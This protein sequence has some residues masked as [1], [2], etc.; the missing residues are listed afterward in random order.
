MDFEYLKDDEGNDI[1]LNKGDKI[2][3]SSTLFYTTA[4]GERKYDSYYKIQTEHG[5]I[6][7]I[8][9]K[10][11]VLLSMDKS[12]AKPAEAE[13]AKAEPAKPITDTGTKP[14]RRPRRNHQP[15][16][17]GAISDRDLRNPPTTHKMFEH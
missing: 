13:P 9:S 12:E 2:T 1:I 3:A 8:N 7:Y 10:D 17:S 5:N 14:V 6:G 11:V 4:E 15:G 16:H